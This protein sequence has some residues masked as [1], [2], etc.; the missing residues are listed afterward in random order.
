MCKRNRKV[1]HETVLRTFIRYE[2]SWGK[3]YE[4]TVDS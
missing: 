4:D 2:S 1:Q 3:S